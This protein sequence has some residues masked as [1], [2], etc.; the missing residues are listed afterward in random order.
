MQIMINTCV[1][2]KNAHNHCYVSAADRTSCCQISNSVFWQKREWP[3]GQRE[4][5]VHGPAV[6]VSGPVAVAVGTG[7]CS[8]SSSLPLSS[9]GFKN[10]VCAPTQKRCVL[11]LLRCA[12]LAFSRCHFSRFQRPL[13]VKIKCQKYVDMIKYVNNIYSI[14]LCT[15]IYMS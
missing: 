8:C 3:H 4:S 14:V 10:A 9:S 1:H 6:D 15:I 11:G 5:F 12:P 2:E 13:Q 7:A